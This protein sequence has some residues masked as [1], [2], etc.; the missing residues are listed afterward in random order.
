M[1]VIYLFWCT[2]LQADQTSVISHSLNFHFN[3]LKNKKM[4]KIERTRVKIKSNVEKIIFLRKITSRP[5]WIGLNVD[6][7]K[8]D[9]PDQ[10]KNSMIFC[11][12]YRTKIRIYIGSV[13]RKWKPNLVFF[14]IGTFPNS[15]NLNI[16]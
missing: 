2:F 4:T 3:R 11:R 15:V 12:N 14:T 8:L 6:P 16:F 1:P 9:V 10:T 7:E 5:F 13:F